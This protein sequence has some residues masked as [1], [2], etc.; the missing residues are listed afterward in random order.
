MRATRASSRSCISAGGRWHPGAV[1]GE[2]PLE[3]GRRRRAPPATRVCSVHEYQVAPRKA[4]RSPRSWLQASESPEKQNRSSTTNT[5]LPRV[6][7]G[8]GWAITPGRDHRGLAGAALEE[9]GG[10]GGRRPVVG[11]DPDPGAEALGPPVGVGHVVAV[12]EQHVGDAAELGEG[13]GQGLGEPGRVDQEVALGPG[14]E[15]G[16]RPERA[17]GAVADVEHAAPGLDLAGV[18]AAGAGPVVD[19]ADRRGG[20]GL[21]RQPGAEL[22]AVVVT[23]RAAGT[24]P[25]S[26]RWRG[27]SPARSPGRCRSRCNGCRQNHAPSTFAVFRSAT[28]AMGRGYRGARP[29]ATWARSGDPP[30][31]T[32]SR[33]RVPS[34]GKIVCPP[35]ITARSGTAV[36][37]P[38]LRA[39]GRAGARFWLTTP[40]AGGRD[41]SQ[42]DGARAQASVTVAI[43]SL[44][45]STVSGV[46]SPREPPSFCRRWSPP[47]IGGYFAGSSSEQHEGRH[48]TTMS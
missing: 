17:L 13:P 37:R 4:V 33:G 19:G 18:E 46:T 44:T 36:D 22:G 2:Q 34:V 39:S 14:D 42:S 38:S 32:S 41:V 23:G 8:T 35:R 30:G 16:R 47:V 21:G 11:V 12:G 31:R 10:V 29:A 43:R 26:R 1:A 25:S 9:V 7:P 24:P 27:R 3:A 40:T 20:A 48:S 5:T 6:W 45:V 15:P 28:L